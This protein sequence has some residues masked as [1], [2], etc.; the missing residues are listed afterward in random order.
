MF[1][2]VKRIGKSNDVL[3]YIFFLYKFVINHYLTY[4][5]STTKQEAAKTYVLGAV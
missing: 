4:F 3:R 2:L 5:F 1:V